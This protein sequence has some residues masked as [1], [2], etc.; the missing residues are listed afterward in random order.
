[1]NLIDDIYCNREVVIPVRVTVPRRHYLS[2]SCD[3]INV[4]YISHAQVQ[5]NCGLENK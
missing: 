1:M 5:F 2:V 4:T 3:Y